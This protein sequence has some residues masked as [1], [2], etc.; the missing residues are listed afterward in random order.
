[1]SK[2]I[3]LISAEIEEEVPSYTFFVEAPNSQRARSKALEI[4]EKDYPEAMVG[5]KY[6]DSRIITINEISSLEDLKTFVIN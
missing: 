1:M 3:F 6:I 2:K 4:V 5:E